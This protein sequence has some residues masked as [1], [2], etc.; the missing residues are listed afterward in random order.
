MYLNNNFFNKA[1]APSENKTSQEYNFFYLKRDGNAYFFSKKKSYSPDA[2]LKLETIEKVFDFAYK[3][4]FAHEGG[5]RSHRNGGS[6]TR[7]LGEIFANTFQGKI[8]ECAACNHFIPYDKTVVPDFSINQ[9]GIWDDCDLKVC[10]KEIAVKSTKSYGELLLLE[11]KDWDKNGFY[12]PNSDTENCRYDFLILIRIK[13]SCED[14]MKNH[15]LL[16]S[17]SADRE[18]LHAVIC[19]ETWGY[20][21]PGYITHDE[22]KYIINHNYLLP[23]DS[24]LNGKKKMDADNYYIQSGDLHDISSI[25][26]ALLQ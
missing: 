4:T 7:R 23:K 14:L 24:L 13:P 10:N 8:A 11:T 9:L 20:D 1:A 5:H 6:H 15:R 19:G 25:R 22:L 18:K 2:V 3:M 26:Q 16:Y 21:C 12:L 17:D